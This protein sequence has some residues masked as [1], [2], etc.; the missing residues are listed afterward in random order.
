[1]TDTGV[2]EAVDQ[3]RRRAAHIAR[4]RDTVWSFLAAGIP[5][6][7]LSHSQPTLSA[8]VAGEASDVTLV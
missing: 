5:I 3:C 7:I 1:M 2:G 6:Y 4:L 8:V